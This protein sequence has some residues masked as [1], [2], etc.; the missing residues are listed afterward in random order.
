M[1]HVQS[2]EPN[3]TRYG[4]FF[5]VVF[6]R[7]EE[8][9]GFGVVRVAAACRIRLTGPIDLRVRGVPFPKHPPVLSVPGIVERFSSVAG[10]LRHSC[11]TPLLVIGWDHDDHTGDDFGRER[12]IGFRARSNI[13]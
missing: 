9:F 12:L 6:D 10:S 1:V 2:P 8:R 11:V 7:L 3:I 5:E 4:L 13:H